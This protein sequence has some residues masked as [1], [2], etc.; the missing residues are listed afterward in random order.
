[1]KVTASSPFASLSQSL[2]AL[3]ESADARA[4]RAHLQGQ[5]LPL[6]GGDNDPAEIIL[7]ALG[8]VPDPK[9]LA[10]RL[11]PVLAQ[12]INEIRDNLKDGLTPILRLQ[13]HQA[14]LL[15]ADL[16][17]DSEL[18]LSLLRLVSGLEGRVS[19][20]WLNDPL[21]LHD[22]GF[23][24]WLK[25]PLGPPLARALVHQQT[26][27]RT[28]KLWYFLL[29]SLSHAPSWTPQQRTILLSAWR[30]L[31][32]IPPDLEAPQASEIVNTT[33]ID[34]GLLIL[35]AGVRSRESGSRMI[36]QALEVLD[37]TFLRPLQFWARNLAPLL[38]RWPPMIQ[39]AVNQQWP[40]LTPKADRP[41][42]SFVIASK[43]GRKKSALRGRFSSAGES[44]IQNDFP[45]SPLVVVSG[46]GEMPPVTRLPKGM[47]P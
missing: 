17:P 9:E 5:K 4:L 28:E 11:A 33:R 12:V 46:Q 22:G 39:E 41:L 10:T 21:P 38:D 35:H 6:I 23:D 32:Y 47:R 8:E 40:G 2:T 31:L 24:F 37:R 43:V 42:G 25:D 36:H 26:D 15:A 29:K 45:N 30:G 19:D 14:L 1:M 3:T 13:I 44:I 20:F 34:D 7:R 27:A 16:P 18:A